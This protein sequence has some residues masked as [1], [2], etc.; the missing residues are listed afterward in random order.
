MLSL[1]NE[2]V[3]VFIFSTRTAVTWFSLSYPLN[4]LPGPGSWPYLASAH[5][6][7]NSRDETSKGHESEEVRWRLRPRQCRRQFINTRTTVDR[8]MRCE[9]V[10]QK[11]IE[12]LWVQFSELFRPLISDAKTKFLPMYANTNEK[13]AEFWTA[14][15]HLQKFNPT[16][17]S[18]SKTWM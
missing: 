18:M 15:E 17:F 12:N 13:S 10:Y 5:T 16:W 3:F 14:I 2:D 11:E 6:D 9:A 4:S 8:T 7:C 1:I